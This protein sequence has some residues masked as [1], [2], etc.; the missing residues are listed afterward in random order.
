MKQQISTTNPEQYCQGTVWQI[1]IINTSRPEETRG[2]AFISRKVAREKIAQWV[3]E[4]KSSIID[5]IGDDGYTYKNHKNE[6]I[7]VKIVE[8][9]IFS[10][11]Q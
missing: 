8:V 6:L 11:A 4:D 2:D 10:S 1:L 5:Y 9:D 3:E 7:I